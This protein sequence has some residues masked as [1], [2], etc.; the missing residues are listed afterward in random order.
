MKLFGLE[1]LHHLG[2]VAY[3]ELFH[4]MDVSKTNNPH[5]H[6]NALDINFPLPS[7]Q[8]LQEKDVPPQTKYGVFEDVLH[9]LHDLCGQMPDKLDNFWIVQLDGVHLATGIQPDGSKGLIHGF[10]GAICPLS[11]CEPGGKL[12][13][14]LQNLNLQQDLAKVAIVPIISHISGAISMPCGLHCHATELEGVKTLLPQLLKQAKEIGLNIL[15]VQSD[16]EI[17]FLSHCYIAS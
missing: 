9:L 4:S 1:L 11:E 12:H 5:L 15:F 17:S 2:E 6:Y 13:S 10:S 7:A 14:M 3:L 8:L 16:G